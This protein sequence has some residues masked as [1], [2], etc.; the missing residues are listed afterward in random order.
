MNTLNRR[1]PMFWPPVVLLMLV[2]TIALHSVALAHEKDCPDGTELF[3]EYHLFFGRSQ[4]G[5]EVVSDTA[6]REFL[7]SEITP[8]FPVGLTVM[9]A[10]GQW[11]NA[12]GEVERERA[13]MVI[14]LAPLGD[15]DLRSTEEVALA[16]KDVFD[17]E[18]VLR[19]VNTTCAAF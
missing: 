4:G 1:P 10:N 15:A 7:G 16:Y 17:Q 2:T 6:W 14:V 12:T 9:D 18:S 11:R 13:K 8:R 3:A 5:A 19:T